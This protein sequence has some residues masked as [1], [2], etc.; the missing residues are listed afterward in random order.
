MSPFL[1]ET[2]GKSNRDVYLSDLTNAVIA[3]GQILFVLIQTDR[4]RSTI[5][6]RMERLAEGIG[7]DAGSIDSHV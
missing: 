1:H 7:I 2:K 3:A 5:L 4:N 6:P